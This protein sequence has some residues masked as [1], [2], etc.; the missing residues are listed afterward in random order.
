MDPQ[1]HLT[2]SVIIAGTLCLPGENLGFGLGIVLGGV[3]VDIDHFPECWHLGLPGSYREFK[4]K[5][6]DLLYEKIFLLLHSYELYGVGL[7]L[8]LFWPM[9]SWITGLLLGG[10]THVVLDQIGNPVTRYAYF[11][12]YRF[13]VGFRGDRVLTVAEYQRRVAIVKKSEGIV[14]K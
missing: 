1:C 14:R 9:P 2:A 7:L 10:L 11:L 5:L 13:A 12:G 3:I 8:T 6:D 4:R